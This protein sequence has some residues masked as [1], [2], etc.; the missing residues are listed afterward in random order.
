MPSISLPVAIVA[1]AG[2]AAGGALL[3]SALAPG[4]PSLPGMPNAPSVTDP[5]VQANAEA[6]RIAGAAAAGQGSTI[7]TSG[8]GV[9]NAPTILKQTLGG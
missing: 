8:S 4:P 3:S 2:I 9:S 7:L 5:S 6:T 1:G